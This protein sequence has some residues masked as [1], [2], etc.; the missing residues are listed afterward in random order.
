MEAKFQFTVSSDLEVSPKEAWKLV[1]T[2]EGVNLELK[3][4]A[5][6]TFPKSKSEFNPNNIIIGKPLFRSWI[7][8]FGILPIDYDEITFQ[9]LKTDVGFIE[10]SKMLSQ[11]LWQHERKL[12]P[13]P[14]GCKITDTIKFTPKLSFLGFFYSF[15]FK[16]AFRNRH[17]NLRRM[18]KKIIS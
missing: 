5:Q 10:S 4:L 18:F 1:G 14:F 2:M 16:L 7:L 12:Q 17:R 6:M 8:L 15:S 13:T 9:T 3:P 11:K